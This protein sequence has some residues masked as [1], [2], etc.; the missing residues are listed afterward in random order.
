MNINWNEA[1][2]RR[3]A[4]GIVIFIVGLGIVLVDDDYA[5]KITVLLLLGKG[6]SD[7]LKFTLP[8]RK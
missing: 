1:S 5:G 2:T 4:V 8:D 6:I 3:G 7:Y